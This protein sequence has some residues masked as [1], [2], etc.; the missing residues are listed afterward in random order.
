MF[1]T[2]IALP[3][4]FGPTAPGAAGSRSLLVARS[5]RAL[6][7]ACLASIIGLSAAPLHAQQQQQ[8]QGAYAPP[9][10][11]Q[12]QISD[13]M[14]DQFLG[15]LS[16]VQ[17]VQQEY[18]EQIQS[19]QDADEAQSLRAE[20]QSRMVGAV[21]QSGLTVPEYNMIAQ[22]LRTD[23]ELAERVSSMQEDS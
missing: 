19:T 8:G 2:K 17:T 12:T 5:S 13:Q 22:R 4:T 7:A 10:Q 21:E 15:A 23:E 6:S 16:E 1:K 18:S 20:A 3:A 11:E 9:A 14:L